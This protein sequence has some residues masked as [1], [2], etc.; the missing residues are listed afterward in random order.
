MTTPKVAAIQSLLCVA[1]ALFVG[2]QPST[3]TGELQGTVTFE[4]QAVK[5][6]VVQFQSPATGEAAATN[7]NDDGTFHLPRPIPVG[8]Y[9][10]IV[11]PVVKEV[12]A[13]TESASDKPQ[14][15]NDI[16]ERYRNPGQNDLKV[17]IRPGKN[18][19]EFKLTK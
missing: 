3:P 15:R 16:P 19:I 8:E 14:T 9:N 18:T 13:G 5:N 11:T 4:G 2:C 10:A 12:A 7:L 17:T 6:A 1:M